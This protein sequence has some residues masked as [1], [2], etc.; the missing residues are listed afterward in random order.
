[1]KKTYVKHVKQ[2][3]LERLLSEE[4]RIMYIWYQVLSE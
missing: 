1:M 3:T 4:K 2:A